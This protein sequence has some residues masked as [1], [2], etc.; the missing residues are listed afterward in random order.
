[1]RSA[2]RAPQ[3]RGNIRVTDGVIPIFYAFEV[4]D[5]RASE[6][7]GRPI[8]RTEDWIEIIVP[9][10]RDKVRVPVQKRHK[11]RFPE[12]WESYKRGDSR[13]VADGT[14][15]TEWQGIPR[16][17]AMELRAMSFYTVEQL[18]QATEQQITKIGAGSR[19]LVEAAKA[20]IE[21]RKAF[22]QERT[23]RA[24]I[25]S[26]YAESVASVDELRAELNRLKAKM[27]GDADAAIGAEP[28]AGARGRNRDR[29]AG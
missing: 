3:G 13:E 2:E 10:S 15:I 4:L 11:E 26:K 21:G 1:M 22:E 27:E 7:A 28:G 17:Q 8:F 18:A 25:E 20:F 23:L 6:E 5:E 14:P 19:Q 29:A 9:A 16:R 12:Q 24:E